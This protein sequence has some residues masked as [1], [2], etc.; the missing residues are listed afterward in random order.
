MFLLAEHVSRRRDLPIM[1][2]R[3]LAYK[4]AY[5]NGRQVWLETL[6]SQEEDKLG[7]V[8]L[9]PDIFATYPRYLHKEYDLLLVG[10]EQNFGLIITFSYSCGLFSSGLNDPLS[11]E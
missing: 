10:E 5:R 3:K 4:P 9:H 8:D 1:T 7:I 2:T 11:T 6:M